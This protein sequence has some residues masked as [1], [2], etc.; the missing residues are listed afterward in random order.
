MHCLKFDYFFKYAAKGSNP[1][2]SQVNWI[3]VI[4]FG[5]TKASLIGEAVL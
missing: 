1:G 5:W 3:F 2:L 4:D